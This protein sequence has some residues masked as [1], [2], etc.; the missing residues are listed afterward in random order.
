MMG[1]TQFVGRAFT[2]ELLKVGHSVTHFNRG[3]TAPGLF[4]GVETIV[5]DRNE[6]LGEIAAREWDIVVDVNAYLPHQTERLN[7]A[8]TDSV[9]QFVFVSTISVYDQGETQKLAEDGPLLELK[10]DTGEVTAETYGAYKVI[11]EGEV[12]DH[13]GERATILR[14]GVIIGPHDHTDRFAYWPWRISEGGKMV[15]PGDQ[16]DM[17]ITGLDVRDFAEFLSLVIDRR[18][19]GIFNV[20][21][22]SATFGDLRAAMRQFSVELGVDVE[23]VV[24]PMDWLLDR[25]VRQWVNIPNL[26]PA[27]ASLGDVTKAVGVGLKERPL[28]DSMRDT[29]KWIQETQRPRPEKSGLSVER[30]KEL[31]KEWYEQG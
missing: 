29:W 24:I 25:D 7:E 17:A 11:C 22:L 20:D 12:L 2:E 15:I 26:L 31:L 14:P 9:Q 19:S 27:D 4:A 6:D 23:E 28:I 13:W 30:E 21:K 18:L 16:D 1:G 10:E 8:L 5:G 3:K